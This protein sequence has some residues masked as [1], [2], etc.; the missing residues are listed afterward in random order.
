M[1]VV[2]MWTQ[3]ECRGVLRG[4]P[5]EVSWSHWR[6]FC[7]WQWVLGLSSLL[8]F[9]LSSFFFF[10]SSFF[11]PS[12]CCLFFLYF[13]FF[14]CFFCYFYFC[15]QF[16]FIFPCFCFFFP[17]LF[18]FFL[19]LFAFSSSPRA[20]NC[21]EKTEYVL[22]SL[23]YFKYLFTLSKMENQWCAVHQGQANN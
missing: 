3:C 18:L 2:C 9:S 19:F 15:F 14:F 8:S 10:S 7:L 17:I 22:Y 1:K 11:L 6:G 23:I 13:C 4:N 12:S 16:S 5:F 21:L 20:S